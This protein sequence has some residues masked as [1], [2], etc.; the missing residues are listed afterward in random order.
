M[1]IDIDVVNITQTELNNYPVLEKEISKCGNKIGYYSICKV[2][3]DEW[4]KI[5]NFIDSKRD[6]N[7]SSCFRFGDK[8]GEYCYQF[9]FIRP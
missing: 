3:K 2:S 7:K 8:Y 1:S 4:H 9:N 5:K 6:K